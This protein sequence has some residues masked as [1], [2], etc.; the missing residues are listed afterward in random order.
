MNQPL[1][2]KDAGVDIDAGDA[3]VE[4]IKPFARKTLR[5]GVLAGIGGFGALFEVP[6]HYR[7]PVMVSG[8]RRRQDLDGHG[9]LDVARV[10]AELGAP[11]VE[12]AHLVPE[13]V[14]RPERVVHVGMLGRELQRDLLSAAADHQRN[15]GRQRGGIG[16]ERM[17]R[18]HVAIDYR[19][20]RVAI[21]QGPRGR[22][23]R[24]D[25]RRDGGEQ[26]R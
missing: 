4:R 5:P 9:A 23:E 3:L 20:E 26:L 14:D 15:V 10:A 21:E 18:Q 19:P 25:G 7:E 22:T 13:I 11:V 6:K 8:E 2:Y 16:L 1:S 17:T 12:N 24:L